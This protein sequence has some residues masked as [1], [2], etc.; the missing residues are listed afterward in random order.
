[1][2][3]LSPRTIERL[4]LSDA[5]ARRRLQGAGQ[6]LDRVGLDQVPDLGV[7]HA[8]EADA[9]LEAARDL[10]DV[11]LEA[12]QRG[13]APAPHRL[14]VAHQPHPGGARDRPRDH[15]AAAYRA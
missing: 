5:T 9:A 15:H 10:L 14:A 12:P 3:S 2:R 1:M 7:V 4:P 11:V 6:L 8:V 13:D